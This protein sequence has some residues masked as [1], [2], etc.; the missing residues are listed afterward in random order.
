MIGS[1]HYQV[2]K[3][4]FEVSRRGRE[5]LIQVKCNE[6][7]YLPILHLSKVEL[8]CKLQEKLLRVTWAFCQLPCARKPKY[9]KKTD[10][11]RQS[12]D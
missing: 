11:F 7:A 10:E 1:T 9:S 6:G 3:Q 8:R 12:I 4:D 2:I 5:L